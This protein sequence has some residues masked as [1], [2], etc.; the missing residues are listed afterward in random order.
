MKSLLILSHA[1]HLIHN[2]SVLAYAPF[3]REINLWADAFSKVTVLSPC[4]NETGNSKVFEN[5]KKILTA[6]NHKNLN[7]NA[8]SVLHFKSVRLGLKS[9][10]NTPKTLVKIYRGCSTA[11]HIHLRCPGN[12]GLL[13]C[14]VQIFFPSTIKTAK[15][16]GNWDPNATNQPLSYR[17]QKWILANPWLTRNM[18]V[19][20][21]GEWPNQSPNIKPF[22]T[23]TYS[24]K[25]THIEILRR[26]WQGAIKF[27]FA[28]T[29]SEGKNP[30]YAVQLIKE[31]KDSGI[32]VHSDIYGDGVQKK[33]I[34]DFITEHHLEQSVV[35]H[36][37]KDADRLKNAYQNAHFLILPS[38]SEGWPKVVAEAM[39]WGAIPITRAVSCVPWMLG[40]GDRGILLKDELTADVQGIMQHLNKPELLQAMSQSGA[41]WSRQYTTDAFSKAIKQLLAK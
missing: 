38:Q 6:Y 39:F 2:G 35:L 8:L 10:F 14:M 40:H 5:K 9:I 16:A 29:L 12:I 27:V 24:E 31:L 15:Y 28:G 25:D 41:D 22:F 19:M 32:N 4:F 3:V 21:Y 18:Q 33:Q 11:D 13:G 26:D 30:F 36:G 17:L 20:A 7:H 37:N 23:A 1:P 34:Q